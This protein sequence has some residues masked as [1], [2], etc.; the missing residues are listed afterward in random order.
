MVEPMLW[1]QETAKYSDRIAPLTLLTK[2]LGEE[3]KRFPGM[4]SFQPTDAGSVRYRALIFI[5]HSLSSAAELL[6]SIQFLWSH[7]HFLAA[8]HCIRLLYELWGSLIY[9]QAKVVRK[10]A[11]AGG[12]EVANERMRKLS[13]GTKSGPLLPA[14]ITDR[15][16]VINVMDFVRAGEEAEPGFEETYNLLCDVSHPSFMHFYIRSLT[17]DGSWANQ[18]F[19]KEAH[20][21]LERITASSEKAVAGIEL[22]ARTIYQECL[23]DLMAEID[24]HA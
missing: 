18:V 13:L 23:P 4:L 2:E 10:L 20:R 15:I 12:T 7:T 5:S 21:I 11:V 3:L 24:E 1:Q 19:A 16:T 6:T 22:Q 17:V 9:A 8:A 14:G